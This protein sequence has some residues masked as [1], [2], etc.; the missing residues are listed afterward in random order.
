MELYVIWSDE[1][2]FSRFQTDGK[3]YYWHCP[4]ERLK[5]PSQRNNEIWVRK[6]GG[7]GLFYLVESRSLNENRR[8]NKKNLLILDCNTPD[9]VE[10]CAYPDEEIIFQQYGYPKHTAKIVKD[11]LSAQKF[12]T[13]Q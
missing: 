11:S 7:V 1:T 12:K 2:K 3:E 5:T 9:F 10:E 8:H 6:F 4:Y 13:M